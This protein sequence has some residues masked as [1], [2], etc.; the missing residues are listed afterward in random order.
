ME[1]Q[2][3]EYFHEVFKNSEKLTNFVRKRNLSDEEQLQ[4][5]YCYLFGFGSNAQ[6]FKP[7]T[8]IK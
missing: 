8:A 2:I 5:R 1:F 4:N 3:L 7:T 6:T